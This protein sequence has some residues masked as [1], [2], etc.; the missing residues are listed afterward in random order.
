MRHIPPQGPR[1]SRVIRMAVGGSVVIIPSLHTH[2][3]QPCSLEPSL[4]VIMCLIGIPNLGRSH[5]RRL[6]AR[7]E[8]A[9]SGG[10][11]RVSGSSKL[12]TFSSLNT[13]GTQPTTLEPTQDQYCTLISTS[14]YTRR[15]PCRSCT[16]ALAH[17][18]KSWSVRSPGPKLALSHVRFHQRD[19]D[20]TF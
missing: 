2:G 16:H 6:R 10:T 1:C 15:H 13:Y 9:Y 18:Q 12:M 11:E 4:M 20:S 19:G 3:T 17:N 14:P 5:N 8:R 7:S